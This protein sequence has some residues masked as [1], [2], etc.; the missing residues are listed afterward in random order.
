M[1]PSVQYV[2][3]GGIGMLNDTLGWLTDQG[4]IATW[5][6]RDGGLTWDSISSPVKNG[7]RLVAADSLNML[8]VGGTVYRYS[9]GTV[10]IDEPVMIPKAP[11]HSLTIRP[12]P[13]TEFVTIHALAVTNTF[14]RIDLLDVNGNMVKRVARQIFSKG[15]NTF[16]LDVKNLNSG[17]YVMIWHNN[18][19]LIGKRFSIIR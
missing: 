19:K 5:E 7:D 13:A 16:T 8:A 4:A 17:E 10:G 6:T 3:L 18:E 12:N 1:D 11:E 9:L 15:E 2:S 14:G